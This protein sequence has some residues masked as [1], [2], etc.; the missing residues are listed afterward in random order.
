MVRR[1]W[2][3]GYGSKVMVRVLGF[4]GYGSKVIFRRSCFEGYVS[5]VMFRRLC[6]GLM[7]LR[8][9]RVKHLSFDEAPT[10]R[11]ATGLK[12]GFKYKYGR[13]GNN[14]DE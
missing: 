3:V 9:V 13:R 12:H 14:G 10:T 6:L 7:G 8:V 5:K 1:L 11:G 2:F 4:E